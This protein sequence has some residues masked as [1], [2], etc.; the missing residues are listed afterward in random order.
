MTLIEFLRLTLE[1]KRKGVWFSGIKGEGE[2]IE[3]HDNDRIYEHSFYKNGKY[4]GE[5]KLWWHDGELVG[6]FLYENGIPIKNY[7]REKGEENE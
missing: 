6:H 1:Q 7:L 4:H 2:H 5:C 3:L